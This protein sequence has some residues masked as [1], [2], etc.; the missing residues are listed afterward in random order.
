MD[1][2]ILKPQFLRMAYAQGYFPMPHP[3]TGEILWF[4]PDPRAILPLDG[5]HASHSL[6][7]TLRRRDFE[8]SYDKAFREVMLACADR[9][10]TWI[11]PEFVE[12]YCGLHS[13]NSAH[14]VEVWRDGSLVGG[15]YG[16]SIGGAF[17]AESMFHRETDMSK[18]ALY[19]LVRHLKEKGFALL[20]VQFLTEHLTSLGAVEITDR[21]YQ[22]LLAKALPIPA[23]F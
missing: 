8:V 5:F 4:R 11:T 22:S 9:D 13:E 23:S 14:S 15:V 21:K 10:D 17:F 1:S 2:S 7:R 3:E 6:R 16:V 20:E 18:V 12:G 19:H